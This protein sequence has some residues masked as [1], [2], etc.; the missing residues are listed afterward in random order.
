MSAREDTM[1]PVLQTFSGGMTVR[2]PDAEAAPPEVGPHG[3]I[4]IG[5]SY[6]DGVGPVLC[7]AFHDP[8]G[9]TIMATLGAQAFA[10]FGGMFNQAARRIMAGE[11]DA[12]AVVQ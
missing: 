4:S 10:Q 9:N 5:P 1:I 6:M 3:G 7:I 2:A 11:F 8:N 12:P